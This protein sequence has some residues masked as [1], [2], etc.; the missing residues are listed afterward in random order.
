VGAGDEQEV[1]PK[2]KLAGRG[3]GWHWDWPG[4]AENWNTLQ[5]QGATLAAGQLLPALQGRH[6]AEPLTGLYVPRVQSRQSERSVL[7]S[8]ALN[9]PAGHREQESLPLRGLYDPGLHKVQESLP[10]RGLYVPGLHKAQ[11]SLPLRG[12]YV[13]G[14]HNAQDLAPKKPL[15]R[16]GAQTEHAEPL[17]KQPRGQKAYRSTALL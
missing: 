16:P 17:L 10:L 4:C 2:L 3:Q 1:A 8:N 12:L 7:S 5:A 6:W 9:D 13:P 11:E 14:L 15:Y